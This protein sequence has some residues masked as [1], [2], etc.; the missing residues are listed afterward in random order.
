MWF[1]RW[2]AR[3]ARGY[4]WAELIAA[5]SLTFSP[6]APAMA[7]EAQAGVDARSTPSTRWWTRCGKMHGAP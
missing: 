4:R 2:E 1:Y 3:M 5:A 6:L 7:Q